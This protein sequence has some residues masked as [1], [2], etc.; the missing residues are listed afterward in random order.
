MEQPPNP[1]NVKD[2]QEYKE[3][4]FES[5]DLSDIQRSES[6]DEADLS[7]LSSKNWRIKVQ[8]AT[9]KKFSE[10]QEELALIKNG[11]LKMVAEN[12]EFIDCFWQ[13]TQGC[14]SDLRKDL[15]VQ[16][17]V[18]ALKEERI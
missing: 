6:F 12:R 1:T 2:A 18:V 17:D 8:R 5:H 15:K 14:F 7:G 11:S 10:I 16:L 9:S 4:T 3:E 13:D